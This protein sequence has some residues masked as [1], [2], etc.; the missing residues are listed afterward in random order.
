MLE[1][2]CAFTRDIGEVN[3]EIKCSLRVMI[4]GRCDSHSISNRFFL[5]FFERTE[6]FS[7]CFRIVC[8]NIFRAQNKNNLSKGFVT[9]SLRS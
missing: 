5:S 3:Y 7:G 4:N 1:V 2:L 9:N 6:H 8:R